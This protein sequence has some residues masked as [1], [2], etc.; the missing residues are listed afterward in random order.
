MGELDYKESWAQK[1]WCFWAMVLVKTLESPL[2]CKE[3][4]T[5]HPKGSQSWIFIGTTDAEAETLVLWPPVVK[6]RLM[7]KP[8]MLGKF[9]G[10]RRGWQRIRWLDGITDS[11][12]MYL[13]KLRE[14]VRIGKPGIL[15]SMGYKESDMTEQLNWTETSHSLSESHFPSLWNGNTESPLDTDEFPSKTAFLSPICSEVQQS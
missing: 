7:E 12:D 1:N 6:N 14:L 2:D 13:S 8:M 10:R 9:E 15:Q 4:Q 11:M 5:V 3:I